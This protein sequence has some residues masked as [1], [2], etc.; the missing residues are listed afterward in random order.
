MILKVT[1]FRSWLSLGFFLVCLAIVASAPLSA[2][3]DEFWRKARA[4][5]V[6]IFT[7]ILSL[8]TGGLW[9]STWRGMQDALSSASENRT[10]GEGRLSTSDDRVSS[11]P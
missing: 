11:S 6:A 5:P 9:F 1:L 2:D 8:V 7:L 10:R 3:E 4:D